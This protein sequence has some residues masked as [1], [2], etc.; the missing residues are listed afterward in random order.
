[1]DANNALKFHVKG[2]GGGQLEEHVFPKLMWLLKHSGHYGVTE[3]AVLKYVIG[4]WRAA[5]IFQNINNIKLI[6]RDKDQTYFP[7]N[8]AETGVGCPSDNQLKSNIV[9]R[10][11]SGSHY[12]LLL[13]SVEMEGY[14]SFES[15]RC[16]E[17]W[18][19]GYIF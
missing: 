3:A 7:L 6:L 14:C 16:T 18:T 11:H 8:Y 4:H 17:N 2:F 12:S 13:Y 15:R 10:N 19:L 5:R 9:G 1:M